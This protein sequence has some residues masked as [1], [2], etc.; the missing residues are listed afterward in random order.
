MKIKA[1][2]PL[3]II[4]ISCQKQAQP[5]HSIYGSWI[6]KEAIYTFDSELHIAQ[7]GI[8]EDYCYNISNDTIYLDYGF[9]FVIEKLTGSELVLSKN[10]GELK[11]CYE[12][13]R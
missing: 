9:P 6:G 5:T 4:F 12:F 3:I 8:I 2:L 11:Y 1:L 13:S 10:D 7:D